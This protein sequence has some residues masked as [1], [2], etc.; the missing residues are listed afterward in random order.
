MRWV[1]ICRS[2]GLMQ[3][4]L[5]AGQRRSGIKNQTDKAP[6]FHWGSKAGGCDQLALI[7][8]M[9]LTLFTPLT[10]LAISPAH[11]LSA[12]LGTEPVSVTAP[13][14]VSTSILR[15]EISGSLIRS[16][17]ICAVM[18]ASS[19]AAPAWLMALVVADSAFI[20]PSSIRS[21]EHTSELQSPCNLVCRL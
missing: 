12:S 18:P 14:L 8:S 17:L 19:S 20:A 2:G 4:I 13:A 11:I 10:D 6:G 15:A 9:L 5:C 3:R 7:S 16:A 1:L 21:E